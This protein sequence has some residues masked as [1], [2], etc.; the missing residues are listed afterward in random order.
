MVAGVDDEELIEAPEV[1]SDKRSEDFYKT[2]ITSLE[3]EGSKCAEVTDYIEYINKNGVFAL[4][5]HNLFVKFFD[6]PP[7]CLSSRRGSV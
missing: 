3:G 5:S 4:L 7:P 6:P 2:G 1:E